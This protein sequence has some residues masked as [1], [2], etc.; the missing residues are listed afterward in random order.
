MIRVVQATG[1]VVILF[2]FIRSSNPS[3][4]PGSVFSDGWMPLE[5]VGILFNDLVEGIDKIYGVIFS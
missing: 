2:P 5:G 1:G 4:G 3:W